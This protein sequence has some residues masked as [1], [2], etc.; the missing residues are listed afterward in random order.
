M[1]AAH[2]A[3]G[4]AIKSNFPKA[5]AWPLLLGAFLPDFLWVAFGLAGVEPSQGPRFF[6][7]WSHSLAMVVFWAT[8]LAVCFWRKGWAVMVPAW[9][10]V[11]SHFF[12]DLP[13]HP[14]QIALFPHSSVHL[15]WNSWEFGLTRSWLGI[16]RYWWIELAALFAL[17]ASYVVGARRNQF[18]M[19]L[20]AAS[21]ITVVGLHLMG[22]A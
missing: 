14:K 16:T 11:V 19:N 10:A 2:F 15:G 21:C 3:A 4:L 1:Y 8:L 12:L 6:D 7:D 9:L 5:S 13:I 20:V 17:S 18:P 22:L